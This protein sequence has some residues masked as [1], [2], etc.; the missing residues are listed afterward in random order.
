MNRTKSNVLA[1]CATLAL[2]FADAAPA[3]EIIKYDRLA[4]SDKGDY[5]VALLQ[6]T[7][8]ILVDA[9]RGEEAVK[10]NKLFSEVHPGDQ[11]SIGMLELE[12]NIDNAR[13]LDAKRYAKDH[14]AVRLEFEHAMLMTLRKNG[15]ELPQTF[16]HV[17][18]HFKPKKP[19]R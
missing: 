17:M 4:I 2:L 6:G 7:Q 12:S 8:K 10:L 16:M 18:D 15:I 11:M 5:L 3:M 13:V 19:L 14:N 1:T 9:G